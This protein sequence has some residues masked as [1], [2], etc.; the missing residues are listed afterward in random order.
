MKPLTIALM[1]GSL[2]AFGC[3][4]QEPPTQLSAA[5]VR[6][7]ASEAVDTSARFAAREKDE[8]VQASQQHL[9]RLNDQLAAL[10]GDA[11]AAH[12]EARAMLETQ[13]AV[14]SDRLRALETR[15]DEVQAAGAGQWREAR[16][17]FTAE[18][19][20]LEQSFERNEG[21]RKQG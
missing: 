18:M 5:E 3:G 8:F 20:A 2:A 19:Q 17:Q 12:G 1:L 13:V 4:R 21:R 14:L 11:R 16:A 15:L 9:N 6:K 10:A 7:E